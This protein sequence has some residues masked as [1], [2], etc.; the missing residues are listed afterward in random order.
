[1]TTIEATH[2]TQSDLGPDVAAVPAALSGVP[3]TA[4]E[5]DATRTYAPP[6]HGWPARL[7]IFLGRAGSLFT[8]FAAVAAALGWFDTAPYGG[9]VKVAAVLAV[10]AVVQL[11]VAN[12]VRRFSHWGWYAAML[13]L[14]ATVVTSIP[15][16]LDPG[17]WVAAGIYIVLELLWMRYFWRRRADFGIDLDV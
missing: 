8:G 3:L 15:L 16:E 4:G 6:M 13:S 2:G 10:T 7:Y 9:P 14:G 1:M 12:A 17:S 5:A 11:T